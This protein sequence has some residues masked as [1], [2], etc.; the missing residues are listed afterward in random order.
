MR[1]TNVYMKTYFKGLKAYDFL[2]FITTGNL[3][4]S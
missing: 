1:A 3:E 4:R 2:D